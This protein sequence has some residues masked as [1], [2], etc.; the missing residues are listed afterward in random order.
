MAGSY[1]LWL[2]ALSIAVAVAAS[3]TAIVLASRETDDQKLFWMFFGSLSMGCG[4][5]TM[6]FIAM[7]AFALPIPMSYDI[8]LTMLS[9][10]YG[11][12]ASAFALWVIK[13]G[14]VHGG[15]LFLSALFMGGGISA[16]HYTGMSAM[17]MAP[18]IRYDPFYFTLSLLIAYFASLAALRMISGLR[19]AKDGKW[20]RIGAALFMGAAICGMHYTAM[21]AAI[22]SPDSLCTA[23]PLKLDNASLAVSVALFTFL[24][25]GSTVFVLVTEPIHSFWRLLALIS[26]SQFAIVNLLAVVLPHDVSAEIR[27]AANI[28]LLAIFISPV[29]WKMNMNGLLL[30]ME[31]ERVQRL[32]HYDSLTGLPN[33]Q[34]LLDHMKLAIAQ[35]QRHERQA[36]VMFLDLDRFKSVNDSLG[37]SFGDLLLKE[38]AERIAVCIREGDTVARMGG[39][40]FVILLHEIGGNQS[41]S[42]TQSA[43]IVAEKIRNII[44]IPFFLKDIEVVVTPSI[45]IAIYPSD[46]D[47]ASDLIKNADAAMYHAKG[48]GR[49]NCQFFA[50]EMNSAIVE[51][52]SME[53]YL[54]RAMERDEFVLHYQPQMDVRSGLIVSAEALIRWNNSNGEWVPPEKFI[55]LAEEC[56]LIFPIGEWVIRTACADAKLWLE[57]YPHF[58]R[59]AVNVSPQQFRQPDFVKKVSKILA[60]IDFRPDNLELELTEG[61]LMHDVEAVTEK[62]KELK[63][64]G[65]GLSIDDFGTGYSSFSYLK[66][67]SIDALKIDRSFIQGVAT[68]NNDASITRAIISMARR[69]NISVVAEGIETQEQLAFVKKYGCHIYQGRL[70]SMPVSR[71]EFTRLL[72]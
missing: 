64:I 66:S 8:F 18:P 27:T 6:H 71:G 13:H 10:L 29:L 34:L 50:S 63:E 9:L 19:E 44:S 56:G 3:Y 61:A 46:A 59:V 53:N 68:D 25:L 70:F 28:L 7:L 48:K 42:A 4:I 21:L 60:E 35:A 30:E 47:N 52:L 17:R 24:I 5:W 38:A 20:K 40:E 69:L 62:L 43:A 31:K 14:A 22:F 57:E 15:K 39:D 11:V 1:N 12:M 32:A 41:E 49:N 65:I 23:V 33:R 45:G 58:K 26:A 2:V 16:M 67:F 51:R 37:H 54:R 36:A 55:H 72:K